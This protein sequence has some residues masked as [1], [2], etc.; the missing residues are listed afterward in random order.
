MNDTP[1]VC[2]QKLTTKGQ[3]C[4]MILYFRKMMRIILKIFK[5]AIDK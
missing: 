1:S 2:K 3:I 5:K 4:G